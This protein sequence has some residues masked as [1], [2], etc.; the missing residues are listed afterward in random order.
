MAP[1]TE[2]I[3]RLGIF[4]NMSLIKGMEGTNMK[5]H[6]FELF[7]MILALLGSAVADDRLYLH[8]AAIETIAPF[9][10]RIARSGARAMHLDRFRDQLSQ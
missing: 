2:I 5:V 6:V 10:S 7:F 9:K 1:V 8:F 4:C 3:S